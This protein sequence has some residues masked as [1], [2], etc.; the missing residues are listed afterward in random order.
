VN[1]RLRCLLVVLGF[2]C[3]FAL[4]GTSG[5]QA[6]AGARCFRETG[7]CIAGPIRDFWEHNGGL[8]VFG[9]PITP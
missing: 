8:M 2:G 1:R 9:F 3:L 4:A 6:Q 7:Y 5:T